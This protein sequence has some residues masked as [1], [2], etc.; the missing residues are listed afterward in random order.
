[1]HLFFVKQCYLR[2]T[3]CVFVLSD[4]GNRDAL[5]LPIK[6]SLRLR[7]EHKLSFTYGPHAATRP[8]AL[9]LVNHRPQM[10][11]E[12]YI[13]IST[14]TQPEGLRGLNKDKLLVGSEWIY[15]GRCLI[16]ILLMKQE[17]WSSFSGAI[18]RMTGNSNH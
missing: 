18:E 5:D 13:Y 4:D 8:S 1:M 10:T 14:C 17:V 16:Y 12:N 2:K 9:V 3:I 7:W 15:Q 11:G 6:V